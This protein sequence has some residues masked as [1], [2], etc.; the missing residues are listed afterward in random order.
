M[1]DDQFLVEKLNYTAIRLLEEFGN[2]I[3]TQRQI[4]LMERLLSSVCIDRRLLL[5]N[6]LSEQEK[7]C[8]Y[9]A[10]RGMSSAETAK[11]MNIAESTVDT[12]RHKVK[13]KLRC[14]SIAHAVFEGLRFGYI[15][16][17]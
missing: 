3:P 5:N 1:S 17:G 13:R 14:K 7:A 4:D 6:S 9:W 16:G 12:H 8:L 11:L 10:A 2:N 15:V